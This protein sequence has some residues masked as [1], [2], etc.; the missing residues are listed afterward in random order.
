MWSACFYSRQTLVLS[1]MASRYE[2]GDVAVVHPEA[3]PEDVR[4][5]LERMG[6]SNTADDPISVTPCLE[7]VSALIL[8][9]LRIT[10]FFV[11]QSLPD[12]LPTT[13]TLREIFTRYLDINAVPR[14]SFFVLL[15]HFTEDETE[16]EKLEEF[17]TTKDGAVCPSRTHMLLSMLTYISRKICTIIARSPGG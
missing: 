13:T 14:R 2:P 17:L 10:Y 1:V 9:N 15:K 5:F 16:R 12:H 4:S 8:R 3:R 6:Y 7:G 11:D